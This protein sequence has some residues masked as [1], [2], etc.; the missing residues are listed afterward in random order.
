M[1]KAKDVSAL[2]NYRVGYGFGYPHKQDWKMSRTMQ[3]NYLHYIETHVVSEVI[4][5]YEV[6]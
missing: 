5:N 4:G 2:R 1:E 6:G 3:T